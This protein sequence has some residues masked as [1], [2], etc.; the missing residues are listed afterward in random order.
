MNKFLFIVIFMS[1]V[2]IHASEKKFQKADS[3]FTSGNIDESITLLQSILVNNLESSEIYYNLGICHFAL[4]NYQESKKFFNKSLYLNPNIILNLTEMIEQCNNKLNVKETPQIF[5]KIWVNNIINT[6]SLN[7]W[8]I[9]SI[10]LVLLTLITLILKL[11]V[12]YKIQYSTIILLLIISFT[13]HLITIQ[14]IEQN[15]KFIGE[16]YF[17]I[18][19]N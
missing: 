19:S 7:Q 10:F 2:K 16:K 15:K 8:T 5:Y 14:K 6:M 9:I 11:N 3:L 18:N 13:V 17:E 12:N 4:E 1:F